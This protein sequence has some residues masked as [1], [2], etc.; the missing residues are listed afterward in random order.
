MRSRP[1]D[2]I[3]AEKARLRQACRAERRRRAHAAGERLAEAFLAAVPLQAD[4]VVSGYW[5]FADEIDPRPL[6][7]ALHDRGHRLCLPV[8]VTGEPLSFR[9]WTPGEAL[10]PGPFDTREPAPEKAA[11]RPDCLLVPL[12]AVDGE[13]YRLGYGGG[14]YDRTLA[15]LGDAISVGLAFSFQVCQRLPRAAHDSP[16]DWLVSEDGAKRFGRPA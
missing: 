14:F 16:L 5:P 8:T 13:G 7:A 10:V 12:L 6:L 3:A 2:A 11:L 15:A 1:P 4:A 9:A